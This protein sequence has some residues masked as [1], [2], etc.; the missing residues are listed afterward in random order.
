MSVEN[1]TR[2][3]SRSLVRTTTPGIFKR[4]NAY[5]VV[6]RD[7]AG[8]QRKRSAPTL[9]AAR[10]VKAD[11]TAD[12]QRGEFRQQSHVTFADHWQPWI[13]AYAGR[14]SRGFRESTRDD[15][16]RA[17]ETHA[18]P[19]FKA[20][21]LAEI[22]PQH[23]KV[24]LRGLAD[25]GLSVSTI[26]N[27]FAPLRA[28]LAD[29][30]EDGL[31]RSNPAAGVRVPA[32]AKP[33]DARPKVLTEREVQALIEQIPAEH[34]LL[35]QVVAE[36]GVRISEALAWTWADFDGMRLH[37]RRRLSRG[38]LGEPKSRYGKR[39]I[40]LRKAT[41]QA[42]WRHRKTTEWNGDEQPLFASETGTPLDASNLY[43]RVLRPARDAAGIE[44]G[45]WHRLRHTAATRLIE[46]GARPDQAQRWLGHHDSAFTVRVYVH[47]QADDLPDP[48]EVW[49]EPVRDVVTVDGVRFTPSR[50]DAR[51][52]S[53]RCRVALH[54]AGG[55]GG[56]GG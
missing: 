30:A 51:T 13:D 31:I 24:W 6:F 34:R 54:R 46:S 40:P 17:L 21:R 41:A 8:K 55:G 9:A 44:Y 47:P 26:R 16:R 23:M 15:Y 5:V 48:D 45:G 4:G 20:M 25:G 52:C 28:M 53:T 7:P 1:T 56:D 3:A 35:V 27:N 50:S 18:L 22:E 2:L 42:L 49:G 33:A 14:T 38:D 32:N 43:H 19:F 39:A 11:V 36:T 12:V 29:A 37:V 10:A